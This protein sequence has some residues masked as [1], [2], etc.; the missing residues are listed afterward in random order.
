[1]TRKIIYQALSGILI[2]SFMACRNNDRIDGIQGRVRF[3]TVSIAS[4]IPGRLA[5][6]RVRDGDTI[7]KDDTLLVLETPEIDAKLAQAEGAIESAKGQLA[8]AVN[9]A[10]SE[11]LEQIRGQV[12]A[13]QAQVAFA[14]KSFERVQSL[15]QDSLIPRQ[16]YD[17]TRMKY[18]SGKA[19]LRALN[20]K[21]GEI[22]KGS[23]PELISQAEG[24]V[25]RAKATRD[26]I[27][28]AKNDR[29]IKAPSDM[30]VETVALK[31]GELASP[32]YTLVNGYNPRSTYFRFTI[33]ESQI[34]SYQ[35]GQ[36]VLVSIPYLN[37]QIESRILSIKQ[38]P[39]YADNTSTSPDHKLGEAM[40]ELKVQPLGEAALKS[41]YANAT[42]LLVNK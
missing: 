38:L 37:Q 13:A 42:V 20:A 21:L 41:L 40:Y 32:G 16:Q 39:R 8:M 22:E 30:V 10:T 18:E 14:L 29:F 4:K 19:Q 36:Q 11:Q 12:A 3:E 23:R 15:F 35:I 5:E 24:Q 17:E 28:V 2:V 6:L 9:G 26:E 1:M 31:A 7:R 27:Q 25:V 34:G 33:M